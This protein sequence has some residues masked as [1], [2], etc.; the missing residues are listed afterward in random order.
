MFKIIVIYTIIIVSFLHNCDIYS[1]ND[2]KE[3]TIFYP[4][5]YFTDCKLRI[6][7][8]DSKLITY[9]LIPENIKSRNINFKYLLSTVKKYVHITA[10]DPLTSKI[11]ENNNQKN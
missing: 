5:T 7:S 2:L 4:D 6:E 1:R 11:T 9:Y 3:I 8:V 10:N